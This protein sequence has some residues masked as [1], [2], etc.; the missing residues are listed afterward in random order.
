MK[1]FLNSK[2]LLHLF[3]LFV[4]RKMKPLYTIFTLAIKRNLLG[5]DSK[6]Y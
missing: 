5:L 2:L 4:V 1:N 3:V 6:S